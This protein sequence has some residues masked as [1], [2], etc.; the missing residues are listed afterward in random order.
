MKIRLFL[1]PAIG[2]ATLLET[3][4]DGAEAA[5]VRAFTPPPG[6]G[7]GG[8]SRAVAVDPETA[9]SLR[10][11]VGSLRVVPFGDPPAERTGPAVELVLSEGQA[12]A[13]LQWWLG[14]P[15]GWDAADRL[16]RTLADLTDTPMG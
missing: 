6:T 2:P 3:E 12:E 16:V 7:E 15:A 13:R 5:H 10:E 4:L 8:A 11:L 1:T 9:A 14:A